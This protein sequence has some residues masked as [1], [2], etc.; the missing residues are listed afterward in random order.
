MEFI[1]NGIRL[2]MCGFANRYTTIHLRR[3]VLSGCVFAALLAFAVVADGATIGTSSSLHVNLGFVPFSWYDTSHLATSFSSMSCPSGASVRGCFQTVLANMR[4]QGVSGVRVFF[5][6]CDS[7]SLAFSNCGQPYTQVAWNPSAQPGQTWIQN[8]ANFF[9]DVH[10]AG[11]QNVTVTTGYSGSATYSVSMGQTSS[12]K[13]SCTVSGNCCPDTPG[14]SSNPPNTNALVY[15]NPTEP[16]GLISDSDPIGQTSL[17]GSTNQG[18]NCAPINPGF[19]GWTNLLNVTNAVLGA[20]RGVVTVNELEFGQQEMNLVQFPVFL[21]YIV[22]NS[23]PLSAGLQAGSL[24]DVLSNLRSLMSSNGFDPGRVTWSAPWQD[25]ADA[26]SNCTDI[27]TDYSRQ[28]S[29]DQVAQAIGGGWIGVNSDSQTIGGLTCG[30]TNTNSMFKV[31]YYNTQP[32]I[33]DSH[34]YPS[35]LDGG[36]GQTQIQQVAA[37]DYGDLPH[38]LILA[39]M[40]SAQ[41]MIGETYAGTIY[42]GSVDGGLCWSV[43]TSAPTSNVAG[44]NQSALASY[45]VVFRPW[46]TLENDSGGCFPY[47]GGPSST[48]NF[49]NVNY[50]GQGPYTPT[51]Q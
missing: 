6:L 38:F 51:N 44:F 36:T 22:D 41:V 3:Q 33:V 9:Q 43:P 17:N 32:D 14:V 12:P 30:G 37:L 25:T 40:Q 47:G 11:I 15:F 7:T 2:R 18:W 16:F 13:G 35:V 19:L 49:Q 21:R 31:P 34:M 48:T 20:A 23:S 26:T 27:Y 4:A 46:M 8:V 10:N 1:R 29:L 42:T 39:N 24:V 50:N 28:F 5:T 45:A